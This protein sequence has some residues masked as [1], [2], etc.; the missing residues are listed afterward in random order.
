MK[1][2]LLHMTEAQRLYAIGLIDAMLAALGEPVD[3]PLVRASKWSRLTVHELPD[4]R[5]GASLSLSDGKVFLRTPLS[6]RRGRF[7]AE[8]VGPACAPIDVIADG[9]VAV[10]LVTLV[11]WRT[12]LS[13]R[14]TSE[15]SVAVEAAA[16]D[17]TRLLRGI[18]HAQRPEWEMATL[19][20]CVEDGHV[21]RLYGREPDGRQS[22]C[23]F[24]NR[25]RERGDGGMTAEL[26]AEI[27]RVLDGWRHAHVVELERWRRYRLRFGATPKYCLSPIRD[28]MHTLRVLSALPSG[29]RLTASGPPPGGAR[30]A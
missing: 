5:S 17:L 12:S 30:D 16:G 10:M 28:P 14:V 20:S 26:V 8:L 21:V 13:A 25:S 18:A 15:T 2:W 7:A 29:A 1:E 11:G 22:R 27:D 19:Q 24:S 9:D 4:R 23:R 3:L 6:P